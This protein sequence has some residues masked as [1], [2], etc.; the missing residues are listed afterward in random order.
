MKTALLFPGQAAQF[1]GMGSKIQA[2]STTAKEMMAKSDDILGYRLSEIMAEGPVERLTQTIYTQPAVY[3]HSML[4]Y[5]QYK[6]KA[7]ASAVAGH[8]LGEI[9]ACVAAGVMTFEDGLILVQ[10]RAEAMQKACELNPSTMAAVLGM[11]D[12]LVE[13]ICAEIDDVVPANYNC[14][15]QLVIS[16]SKEGITLAIEKCKEAGAKRALEIAVGGA[17]HSP[18]MQ[19]AMD[20]FRAAI[21]SVDMKDAQIPVYQNVDTQPHFLAAEIRDNLIN[22]V[23]NPV[24]WTASIQRMIADGTE[25]FVEVGGRGKILLGMLRKISREVTSELWQEG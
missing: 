16:G 3:L 25:N 5:D 8:S 7:E 2:Q 20:D 6:D 12:S 17:F 9:S 15:G 10:K 4:V 11:E 22:Q 19:P 18:Y 21:S 13:S 24:R 23:I 1:V 14:P